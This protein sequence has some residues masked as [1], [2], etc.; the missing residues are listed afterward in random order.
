MPY[1][2]TPRWN[3]AHAAWWSGVA[4]TFLRIGT[5]NAA[6]TPSCPDSDTGIT[7]SPG[8]CA[9]VFADNIGHV[10][11]LVPKSSGRG[12]PRRHMALRCQQDRSTVLGCGALGEGFAIDAEDARFET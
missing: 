6:P 7:L 8:F 12:H 10:R 5:V 9:S 3:R 2:V 4:I 1:S 11:H